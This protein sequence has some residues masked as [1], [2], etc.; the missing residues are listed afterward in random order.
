MVKDGHAGRIP[1]GMS[2]EDASTLGVAIT[3]D[4]QAL[5]HTLGLPLPNRDPPVEGSPY[6]L[7]YGGSTSTGTIAIQ[8]AKL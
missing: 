2:F 7:V 8:L 1:E 3:A 6:L 4:G 5:Y